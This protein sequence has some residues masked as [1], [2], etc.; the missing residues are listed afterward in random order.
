MKI[1]TI[2]LA[3]EG[4]LSSF[5]WASFG[6]DDAKVIDIFEPEQGYVVTYVSLRDEQ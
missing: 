4:K 5:G 3:D 1:E 6:W 2:F